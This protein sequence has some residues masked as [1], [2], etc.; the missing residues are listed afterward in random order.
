[1]RSLLVVRYG[2]CKKKKTHASPR[3]LSLI[4]QPAPRCKT[5]LFTESLII[6]YILL[7]L[8]ET[9]VRYLTSFIPKVAEFYY[10]SFDAFV[11]SERT[12]L[13]EYFVKKDER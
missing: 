5:H 9:G 1:M 2:Y 7:L 12:P 11:L 8:F 13:L 3:P 4:G 6:C 10:E